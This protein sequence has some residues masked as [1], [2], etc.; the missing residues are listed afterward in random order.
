MLQGVLLQSLS[1]YALV[2]DLQPGS[3]LR[4]LPVLTSV[5]KR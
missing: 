4:V 5:S 3:R 1:L 2:A